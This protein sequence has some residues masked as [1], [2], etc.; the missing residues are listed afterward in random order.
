[1]IGR[2]DRMLRTR[3]P[4]GRHVWIENE[5]DPYEIVGVAADAK[6]Q[7]IRAAAPPTV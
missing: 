1:M 6:Y 7:D 2:P 4:I 3:D 5:R